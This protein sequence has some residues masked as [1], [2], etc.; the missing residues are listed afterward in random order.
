MAVICLLTLS[1]SNQDFELGVEICHMAYA[2]L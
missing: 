2:N 1:I